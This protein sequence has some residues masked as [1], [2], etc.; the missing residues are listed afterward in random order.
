MVGALTGESSISA[1]LPSSTPGEMTSG[2][3]TNFSIDSKK[4]SIFL[5]GATLLMASTMSAFFILVKPLMPSCD[6]KNGGRQYNDELTY[7]TATILELVPSELLQGGLIP[8]A[9]FRLLSCG[10]C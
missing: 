4:L 3:A 10:L 1:R 9:P 6:S 7:L 8:T 5:S 2:S